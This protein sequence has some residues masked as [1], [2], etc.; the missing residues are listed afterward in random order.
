MSGEGSVDLQVANKV[1]L[2]APD[3]AA[4]PTELLE[5]I[6]QELQPKAQR[7]VKSTNKRWNAIVGGVTKAKAS[8]P[9]KVLAKVFSL[10]S[11]QELKVAVSVCQWWKEIGEQPSRWTWVTP[12]VSQSNLGTAPE[13]LNTK[14]LR[15]VEIVTVS[16]CIITK[17]MVCEIRAP[18]CKRLRMSGVDLSSID[19]FFLVYEGLRGLDEVT[20]SHSL[21][22]NQAIK[23]FDT[24][25]YGPSLR[26]LNV[27]GTDLSTVVPSSLVRGIYQ[28]DAIHLPDT[29][30]TPQQSEAI[31][32]ALASNKAHRPKYL[33]L[34]NDLSSL[35][36]EL[37][38]RGV[39]KLKEACLY[40]SG[41][42]EQQIE[43][44]L[45]HTHTSLQKLE[46][47]GPFLR[48][49]DRVKLYELIR[50]AGKEIKHLQVGRYFS[51]NGYLR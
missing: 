18:K 28:V 48:S 9:P 26:K 19:P 3:W 50:V 14:R 21:T 25:G 20:L 6:F 12:S 46:I 45:T 31:F 17:E 43:E 7:A 49:I 15:G 23:L 37:L 38:S 33:T 41:I 36:P 5:K 1:A 39:N 44:I 51:M 42:T 16:D 4:L 35:N 32:I 13:M 30:L 27:N 34:N 11:H 24:L 40:S 29:N 22:S 47:S 8:L 10:L 2:C